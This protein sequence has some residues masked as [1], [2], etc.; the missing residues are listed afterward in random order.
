M[1]AMFA[2]SNLAVPPPRAMSHMDLRIPF[3]GKEKNMAVM[4]T[5]MASMFTFSNLAVPPPT[6]HMVAPMNP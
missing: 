6:C 5:C 2:F 4:K 1:A 3:P